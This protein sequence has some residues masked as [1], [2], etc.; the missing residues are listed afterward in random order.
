MY[1][2]FDNNIMCDSAKFTGALLD[3]AS[4]KIQNLF[5]DDD[6]SSSDDRTEFK[7]K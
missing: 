7:I 1:F 5:S 6:N 4:S 2:F 3:F